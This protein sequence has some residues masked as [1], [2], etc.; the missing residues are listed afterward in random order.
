MTAPTAQRIS[1]GSNAVQFGDLYP[2]TGDR[3]AGTV[4]LVHGGFWRPAYG[5]DYFDPNARDLAARGWPV[6]SLEYRR[7]GQGPWPA[8]LED[9]AAGVDHLRE[10]GDVVDTGRVVVVGHSAGGHLATWVAGRASSLP[11]TVGATP[12]VPVHGAVS[13]AGVLDLARAAEVRT[14]EGATQQ[15][16]GGEPDEVPDRYAAADPRVRLPIAVPVRCVHGE[17]DENVPHEQSVRYVEAATAAGDDA[18]LR[19]VAGDH[20][21]L[22]D[23]TGPQ[24]RV[25][26]E[27]IAGLLEP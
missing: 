1:Y 5:L 14:G 8:T 25:V 16:L 13:L 19:S 15:F 21:T 22:V 12:T 9:V 3:R 24:W 17:A 6:W 23:P 20:F 11:G 2:A 7:N 26:V 10:L 27:E 4:V 18:T